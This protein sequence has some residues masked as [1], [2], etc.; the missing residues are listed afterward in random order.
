MP[1]VIVTDWKPINHPTLRGFAT[2]TFPS[3]LIF[4]DISIVVSDGKPWAAPPSKPL[5]DKSGV[6]LR[7]GKGKIRYAPIV[8]F[9]DKKIRDRWSD[10]VIT[11]LTTA[12]PGAIEG[13]K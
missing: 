6:A 9:S 12:H 13:G 3:G 5:I 7:D 8:A 10:A 4:N 1:E 11:A 2:V